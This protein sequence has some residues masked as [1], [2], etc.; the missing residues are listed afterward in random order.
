M[1]VI[2]L[3]E[4]IELQ[5]QVEKARELISNYLKEERFSEDQYVVHKNSIQITSQNISDF[6]NFLY[7]ELQQLELDEWGEEKIGGIGD[8]PVVNWTRKFLSQFYVELHNIICIESKMKEITNAADISVKGIVTA[9]AAWMMNILNITEP[10]A[11]GIATAVLLILFK[12]T[13]GAFCNMSKQE[14]EES[15]N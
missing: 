5:N 4:N 8:S 14:V 13:R 7:E 10:L 12:A 3:R 2:N 6:E 1:C 15:L 11:T 9:I